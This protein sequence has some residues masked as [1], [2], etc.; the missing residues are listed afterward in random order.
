MNAYVHQ[1]EQIDGS[2]TGT[3]WVQP[4]R[5]ML[6]PPASGRGIDEELDIYDS[7]FTLGTGVINDLIELPFSSLQPVTLWLRAGD[8][9]EVEFSGR[10]IS[11]E[12]TGEARFV[13][14]KLGLPPR[15]L[16]ALS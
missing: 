3:G 14:H 5:L 7:R 15:R 2:W 16:L 12:P 11:L 9:R 10:G 13:E 8:G 1:W 4:V 6:G